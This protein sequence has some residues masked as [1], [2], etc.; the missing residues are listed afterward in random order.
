MI[1]SQPV[2]KAKV[3]LSDQ[4]QPPSSEEVLARIIK[5]FTK[6]EKLLKSLELLEKL[7]GSEGFR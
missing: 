4:H 3:E 5:H 6:E 1:S 2:K 7:F